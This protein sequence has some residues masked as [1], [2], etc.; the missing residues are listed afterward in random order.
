MK[1][2]MQ[3]INST[4]ELNINGVSV[5]LYPLNGVFFESDSLGVR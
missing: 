5:I 4:F 3:K 1:P 2:K